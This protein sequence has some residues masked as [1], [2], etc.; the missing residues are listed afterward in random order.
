M[1]SKTKTIYNYCGCIL[2]YSLHLAIME[3]KIW[4]YW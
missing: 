4:T 3:D 2:Y 1:Q